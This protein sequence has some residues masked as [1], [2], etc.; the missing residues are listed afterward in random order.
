MPRFFMTAQGLS[1]MAKISLAK[2]TWLKTS[3][4]THTVW[5][6]TH[7]L[8]INIFLNKSNSKTKLHEPR[9]L[10]LNLTCHTR[11]WPTMS[12]PT[13]KASLVGEDNIHRHW[14][15]QR[16]SY[17]HVNFVIVNLHWFSYSIS[18]A[19]IVN[20][21]IHPWWIQCHGC[22]WSWI[23]MDTCLCAK[24]RRGQQLQQIVVHDRAAFERAWP[25]AILLVHPSNHYPLRP[26]F[27]RWRELQQFT[28]VR[29]S[30]HS[31][32]QFNSMPCLSS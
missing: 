8:I 18:I 11:G 29:L 7:L 23:F 20:V 19:S 13:L 4:E 30:C 28:C 25:A 15:I 12:L 14:L 5:A 10:L 27:P 24:I 3:V 26:A 21:I 22:E 31:S 1:R 2:L 6:M 32:L 17:F 9:H 16:L